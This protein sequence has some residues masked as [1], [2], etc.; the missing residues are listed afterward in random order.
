MMGK[1]SLFHGKMWFPF[2]QINPRLE[3]KS[4][5]MIKMIVDGCAQI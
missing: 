4:L 3:M 5:W 1:V 2:G